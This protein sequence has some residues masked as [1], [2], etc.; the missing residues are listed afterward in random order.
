MQ[1]PKTKS[2]SK[3]PRKT[4]VPRRRLFFYIKIM[5]ISSKSMVELRGIA[6]RSK[7]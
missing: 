1:K 2:I 5:M 7:R 3:T 6:P 4:T